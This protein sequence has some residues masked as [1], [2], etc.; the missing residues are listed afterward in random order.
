MLYSNR[1][2]TCI[3]R[4]IIHQ[5]WCTSPIAL[6][7]HRNPQHTSFWLLSQPL[8]HLRLIIRD[9]RTSLREFLDTVVN[10]FTRQTL[11]T[12]SRKHFFT[13]TLCIESFL[14]QKTHNRALLFGST[15]HKHSR[16]FNYWNQPLNMRMRVC[17]LICR[18][19]G[20][21][22]YLVIHVGN[23]LHP[24]QLFYFHLWTISLVTRN[25]FGSLT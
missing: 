21:C 24:L 1:G 4:H 23:L 20:L 6:P 14:P 25:I 19:A 17:Y 8:R 22:C 11:P 2:K 15:L 5:H 13:N 18:E 9:F 3:S 16:Y 10:R 12:V 7:V